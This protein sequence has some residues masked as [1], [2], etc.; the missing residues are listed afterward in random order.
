[1]NSETTEVAA[2]LLSRN[3]WRHRFEELLETFLIDFG[4]VCDDSVT[5]AADS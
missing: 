2:T 4:R 5:V 1:M 3:S